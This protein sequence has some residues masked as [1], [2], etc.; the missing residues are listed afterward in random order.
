MRA[1][2]E[3]INKSRK[4]LIGN[5][6]QTPHRKVEEEGGCGVVGFA[7]NIKIKG[8]HI[9]KPC[10]QMHNR[11]NGKGGGI[12]AAGLDPSSLGVSQDILNSHNLLQ[13][14]FLDKKVIPDLEEKYILPFFDIAHMQEVETI[15]NYRDLNM[16]VKPPHVKR[17]FVRVKPVIL[18]NFAL[19][20]SNLINRDIEDEFIFQ[21]SFK[22][23]QNYYA[24]LG[25][26]K[27]F[28]LSHA[29]NLM[30]LKVVGY[31]E[32]IVKYYKLEKTCAHIWIAH[33]R[34][35][36]KGKVWHPG[37]AHPFIG[38]NE[39]LV[40]NGDFA[41]YHS[42]SEYLKQR[43]LVPQ[44]LTDT[45]VSVMLF[46]LWS[47]TYKYPLEYL[48]EGLAPT[49][50]LDFDRLDPEKQKIY[51]AIQKVHIHGS[52]DGPWFFI[53]AQS[54][55]DNG[56]FQLVGITDTSMLRPQVFALSDGEA[57][58]GLCASEKQAIDATLESLSREDNRFRPVADKYWNARGG[59]HS[60]GGAFVFKLKNQDDIIT[61]S[62]FNKFGQPVCIRTNQAACS[63]LNKSVK[64]DK[65]ADDCK[66]EELILSNSPKE[67]FNTIAAH[68]RYMSL[69]EFQ[70][71]VSR[72][73]LAGSNGR[74]STVMEVLTLL[75]DRQYDPGAKK[76]SEVLCIIRNGI[77]SVLD[78]SP[79]ISSN[80][81]QEN[82][83]VRIT[84]ET[85]RDLRQPQ[86][87]EAA[88]VIDASDFP[89]E[90]RDCDALLPVKAVKL[91][92]KHFIVYNLSGQRFHGCGFGPDSAEIK[93]DLYG[94]SGDYAG[95]GMQGCRLYIHNDA[96]DQLGQILKSGKLTVFGSVGQTFMYG[97][98]G[99]DVYVMG[100]AAGRPLINAVGRPRVIINGTCLDF[101]AESFMAGNPHKNGGFVIINGIEFDQHGRIRY[102]PLPY[103]GSNLF[104]LASG[105]ALFIRDPEKTIIPQQLNGGEIAQLL[106]NDWELIKPYLQE[107]EKLFGI[108]ISDLLNVKGRLQSPD[109]VYC[110]I[111]PSGS[112]K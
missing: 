103:P 32:N 105:G 33:Q 1:S 94:S 48:I 34:Y 112:S 92:W 90:G 70:S 88:L 65:T 47:R 29:R 107:N 17:Y 26:Q 78:N 82:P 24:S 76:R 37:G 84:W 85:R 86:G 15:D 55:P 12:A 10:M 28:V 42:V 81:N 43:N 31:A 73:V 9:F 54:M 111:I 67:L 106:P 18:N 100:D 89:P 50:E 66:I 44:F 7:S 11:G 69:A 16:E 35:P 72:I 20:F 79:L 80:T 60:D 40:H 13:V 25:D 8:S 21:N 95:S 53:I 41:N 46:D 4:E 27:A 87:K 98:K 52:P 23:N 59:S 74:A 91:G 57:Q 45:E 110:K 102:L 64:T 99:G 97:A 109:R 30:I 104:S 22:I 58:I 101:L 6:P 51:S 3:Q 61:L 108:N 83:Y 19:K 93:I 68:A 71:A 75:N 5:F 77:N 96:Q 62:C 14:A 49:T 36:T 38:M 39:A 63:G 56:E 2:I